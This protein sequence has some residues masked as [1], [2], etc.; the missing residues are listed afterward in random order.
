MTFNDF[1]CK[2]NKANDRALVAAGGVVITHVTPFVPIASGELRRSGTVTQSEG[3]AFV[4]YGE[5][6][7]YTR[8]QYFDELLHLGK[9]GQYRPLGSTESVYRRNYREAKAQ[10]K[11]TPSRARWFDAVIKDDVT[12]NRVSRVYARALEASL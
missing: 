3:K 7:P 8:K 1:K 6:L 10:K 11:L 5:G 12:K 4:E 9:R 2:L